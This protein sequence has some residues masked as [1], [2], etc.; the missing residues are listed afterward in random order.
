MY[1]T[2]DEVKQHLRY[3]DDSNDTVLQAYLLASEQVIN[4]F[5][6]D[7]VTD[8]MLPTLKVATFLLCGHFD[9]DRNATGDNRTSQGNVISHPTYSSLPNSVQLLLQPYRCPTAI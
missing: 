3:D 5:I 8:E 6:T 7:T 1:A 4:R 9:N 2:L